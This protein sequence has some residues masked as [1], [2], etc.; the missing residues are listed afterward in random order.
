MKHASSMVIP[1]III[2]KFELQIVL[3]NNHNVD[4][5]V[6]VAKR[7]ARQYKKYTCMIQTYVHYVISTLFTRTS[8]TY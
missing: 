7:V 1:I 5:I 2:L 3:L 6:H 8:I 4:R